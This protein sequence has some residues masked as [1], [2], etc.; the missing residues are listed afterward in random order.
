MDTILRLLEGLRREELVWLNTYLAGRLRALPPLQ[1]HLPLSSHL[2]LLP[3]PQRPQILVGNYRQRPWP[4][5]LAILISWL[6]CVANQRQG[7]R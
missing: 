6:A 4:S 3:A 2:L 7:R 1:P 5:E